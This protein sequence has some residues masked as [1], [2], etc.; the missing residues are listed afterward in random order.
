MVRR[1]IRSVKFNSHSGKAP[2]RCKYLEGVNQ[3]ILVGIRYQLTDVEG[4]CQLFNNL[5]KTG[6]V[7]DSPLNI[8]HDTISPYECIPK[9]LAHI[10]GRDLVGVK[11]E[12][13][14]ANLFSLINLSCSTG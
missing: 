7:L 2:K 10:L 13:L 9:L 11:V 8:A 5:R 3:R 1:R 12:C 6:D 4:F 14:L